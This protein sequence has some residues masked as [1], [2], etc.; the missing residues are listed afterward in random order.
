ML[1]AAYLGRHTGSS[2]NVVGVPYMGRLGSVG[3]RVPCMAMNVL[4]VNLDIDEDAPLETSLSA[5]ARQLQQSRRRLSLIH[6]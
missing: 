5:I 3:A 1:T 2:A 6:I 4:P